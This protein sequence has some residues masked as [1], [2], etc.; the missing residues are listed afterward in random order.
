MTTTQQDDWEDI[1]VPA[2]SFMGWGPTPNQQPPVVGTVITY[3]DQDGQDF[4]GKPCPQVEVELSAPTYS[5][6]KEGERFDYNT[7]DLVT[8]T[9]G[10]A[11]LRKAVRAAHLTPGDRVSIAF[12]ETL[13]VPKGTV[14]IFTVRV[15]RGAGADDEP[16]F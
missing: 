10:G 6:N 5:V 4:A 13:K 15:K 14:K 16:P 2:G 8:V 11:N 1:P 9:A 12:T 3:G 7:G